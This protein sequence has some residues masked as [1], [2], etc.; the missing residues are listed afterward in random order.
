M[1]ITHLE[2][3]NTLFIL[4]TIWNSR[5]GSPSWR[6]KYVCQLVCRNLRVAGTHAAIWVT[7]GNVYLSGV[8][9]EF[10]KAA[11]SFV[12]ACL[13]CPSV[14]LSVRMDQLGCH[15][16]DFDDIWYLRLFRKYVGKIQV[17]LKPDDNSGYF[18]WRPMYI[19]D[20]ISFSFSS[21]EKS[22]EQ[23]LYRKSKHTFCVQ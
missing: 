23:K 19:Y 8:V 5:N 17:S 16:T 2:S 21:N 20:S 14:C 22:L 18:I 3:L 12:M 6:S 15:W 9:A 11:V 10:R 13:V 4:I 7:Y 1:L